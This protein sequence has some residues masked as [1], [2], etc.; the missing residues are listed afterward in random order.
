MTGSPRAPI[1]IAAGGTGGHFFPAE[2]LAAELA[3]R[4]HRL[5]LMTDGR[6]G[7]RTT[8]VFAGGEQYVLS[9]AGIAGHGIRRQ[10]GAAMA[11][12]RGTLE[13]RRVL[14]QLAPAAVVGFGGYPSVPPLLG[15]RLTPRRQRPVIV[16]HEGNAVLGQA[17]AQLARF[18]DAIAT[19][20]PQVSRLPLGANAVLTGMPVRAEIAAAAG[21]PYPPVDG[22]FRLLVWGGSLGARVFS[23]IVPQTLAAL[24][25]TVRAR[26]AVT[27]QAR[28]EDVERV[29]AAY[30][31]AGIAAEIAPFF[32]GVAQRLAG[33]HLVIG[34]AGG[35][36]VAE[37]A[38]VGRPSIMVPLPIAASDEQTANAASLVDAG[39]GWMLRQSEFTPAALG[40]LLAE[41]LSQP[42]RLALAAL[43]ASRLGRPN[44]AAALADLLEARLGALRRAPEAVIPAGLHASTPTPAV[45]S[46]DMQMMDAVS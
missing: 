16:L 24:P 36:S 32:D 39:G 13:A 2:A 41:L 12:G 6:A 29:R 9:G 3:A 45:H 28:A 5:V 25:D 37:L 11:L 35:S 1:V 8:G 15:A 46:Q 43:A 40:A 34:R 4:G 22:T 33:S 14:R 18:A 42:G 30:T 31:A 20:F 27:Q 44:A 17:N 26:L 10:L 23:D 7:R 19:S 38:M 21:S